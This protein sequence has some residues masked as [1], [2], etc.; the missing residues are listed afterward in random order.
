MDDNPY[1]NY[2]MEGHLWSLEAAP[3]VGA[4][5]TNQKAERKS[6]VYVPTWQV[7]VA[8]TPLRCCALRPHLLPCCKEERQSVS[9]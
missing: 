9:L 3:L 2:S 1:D 5:S 6:N 4:F 7:E 8:Q